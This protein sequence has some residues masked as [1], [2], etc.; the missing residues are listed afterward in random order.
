M[1]TEAFARQRPG[2]SPQV[3]TH[4]RTFGAMLKEGHPLAAM[5]VFHEEIGAD[6]EKN[7]SAQVK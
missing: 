1:V 7:R 3:R 4:L 5:Q 6:Q 2:P